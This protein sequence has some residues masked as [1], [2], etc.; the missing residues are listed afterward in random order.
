MEI[1]I[2][3]SYKILHLHTPPA[4]DKG[5]LF[6]H[7]WP[8]N[9]STS[10]AIYESK[11]LWHLLRLENIRH[12]RKQNVTQIMRTL[13]EGKEKHKHRKAGHI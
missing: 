4:A 7:T 13:P 5:K 11:L 8:R 9:C 3:L 12:I 1:K 10:W 2:H 6:T